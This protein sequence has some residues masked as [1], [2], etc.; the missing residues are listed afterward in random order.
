MQWHGY[1]SMKE[2]TPSYRVY[3]LTVWRDSS[4][5]GHEHRWYFRL[6]DPR[7]GQRRGF[8]NAAALV[9]ALLRELNGEEMAT[10]MT[11]SER[12]ESSEEEHPNQD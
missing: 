11:A 5:M 2:Q 1:E 12:S 4:Q 7:T 9:M 10:D 8:A 3:L 6:E